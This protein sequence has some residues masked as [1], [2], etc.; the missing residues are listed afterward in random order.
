MV[1]EELSESLLTVSL[2]AL[3][4]GG[5]VLCCEGGGEG[6]RRE[7]LLVVGKGCGDRDREEV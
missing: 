6:S 2:L 4:G 5:L 3:T 1:G 7:K